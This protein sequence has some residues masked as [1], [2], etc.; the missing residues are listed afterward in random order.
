MII[1]SRNSEN[2]RTTHNLLL[3]YNN[4]HTRQLHIITTISRHNYV[5]SGSSKRQNPAYNRVAHLFC[6]ETSTTQPAATPAHTPHRQKKHIPPRP[7]LR[8]ARPFEPPACSC[9]SPAHRPDTTAKSENGEL[10]NFFLEK[11][12]K[13][14]N[15]FFFFSAERGRK[16]GLVRGFL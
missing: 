11:K 5:K 13:K 6:N 10:K 12:E 9:T 15:V 3:N 8:D 1:S 14:T 7:S 16:S 2:R 4:L